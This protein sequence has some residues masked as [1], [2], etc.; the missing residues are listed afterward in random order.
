MATGDVLDDPRVLVG[1]WRL[2]RSIDDRRTGERLGAHGTLVVGREDDGLLSWREDGV[3][4]RPTGEMTF[5]RCLWLTREAPTWSVRF[6]DHRAFHPWSP[7][8]RVT[9][10]CGADVYRGLVE[11]DVAGWRVSWL[12]VGPEKDYAMVTDLTAHP[13]G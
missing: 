10:R 1:T 12:V 7:G 2:R 6:D 3:L 5:S 13:E 4:R 9:H 11:G 8:E